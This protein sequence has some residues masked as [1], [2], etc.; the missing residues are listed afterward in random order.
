VLERILEQ[1]IMDTERDAR[2]YA[3]FDNEAVNQEF[4]SR[5]I[6]LAPASGD[7]LDIGTGPGDISILLAKRN[8]R[9]QILAVDLGTHMLELAR[10]NVKQAGLAGRIEVA[11][12][13][14]KA[15]GLPA[16]SFDMIVCNSLVH[17]I[18]EPET[19]LREVQRLA[20][21]GAGL[22]IKDLHRPESRAELERLVDVHARGCTEYQRQTFLASLHAG[23][24]VHEV[25]SI[26]ARLAFSGVEIR[27][28]SDRHWCLE[29]RATLDVGDGLT[30]TWQG[31][32]GGAA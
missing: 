30:R 3:A 5:A 4:V 6:E 8:P 14:A 31:G 19:L 24:T 2:E 9:L 16:G 20:R 22:L 13:D 26:C 12:L 15:T 29:R 10:T 21:A 7:V 32:K 25:E 27:R 23:L 11:C 18:P 17:H 28:C 1:E